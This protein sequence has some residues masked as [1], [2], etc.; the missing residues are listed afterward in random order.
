MI[1]DGDEVNIARRIEVIGTAPYSVHTDPL[2]ADEDLDLVVDGLEVLYS[3]DPKKYDT[4][5]DGTSDKVEIDR[6]LDADANNNTNPVVRDQ[7]LHITYDIQGVRTTSNNICGEVALGSAWVTG[8]YYYTLGGVTYGGYYTTGE[9]GLGTTY[10]NALDETRILVAAPG[11]SIQAFTTDL[12]R[13]DGIVP[14][15]LENVNHTFVSGNGL[16]DSITTQVFRQ[17]Q[18]FG[19]PEDCVV[20]VRF[21]ITPIFN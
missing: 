6:N 7:L 1:S 19:N 2:V 21:T 12:T 15:S 13:W 16:F 5:G 11:A 3:T 10:V 4:D 17:R 8:Y 20:N 9:D 18:T 14:Y